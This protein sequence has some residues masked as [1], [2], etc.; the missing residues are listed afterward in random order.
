MLECGVR[1]E[2]FFVEFLGEADFPH[3]STSLKLR[4]MGSSFQQ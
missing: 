4:A 2:G 3:D 1:G